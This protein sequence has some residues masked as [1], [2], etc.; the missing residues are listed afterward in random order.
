MSMSFID[1]IE[2]SQKKLYLQKFT[3]YGDDARS[4]S[5]NDR[6]TQYLRFSKISELFKYQ[7]NDGSNFTVHEVG[8]GLAHFKEFLN[9]CGYNCTYSGSDIIAEFIE[10]DKMRHP[11]NEFFQNNIAADYQTINENIKNKDYYCLSGTCHT[12][13]DNSDDDWNKF[14]SR[15][16]KNMFKMANKAICI[17]FLST[18]SYFFDKRLYYCDPRVIT[19]YA[20]KNLSRFVVVSHDVP[21]FE[22]FVYIY[23]EEFIRTVFA[24]YDKYFK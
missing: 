20:V 1:D 2:T 5:W 6:K 10:Q 22:F 18:Y 4:L 21:L 11:S 24:G 3:T 13:E 9:E 7:R 16:I 23:K 14:I 12:K 15:A 8:C 19:D 17:N